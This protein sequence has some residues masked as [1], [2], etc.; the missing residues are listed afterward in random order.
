MSKDKAA[1]GRIQSAVGGQTFLFCTQLQTV[2]FIGNISYAGQSFC[3]D[4]YRNVYQVAKLW[5]H[6]AAYRRGYLWAETRTCLD[7]VYRSSCGPCAP[8][9]SSAR[10]ARSLIA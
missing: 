10:T 2:R 5:Q 1:R 4:E 8:S 7:Q 6:H 9:N 3:A